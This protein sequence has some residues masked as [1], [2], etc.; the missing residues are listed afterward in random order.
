MP[1]LVVNCTFNPPVI[2]MM[3]ST[4]REETVH[5]LDQ[6]LPIVTTTS[7]SPK[8]ELPK[9]SY[10]QNPPHWHNDLG[11][12]FCDQLGRSMIFL[13]MIECL[14]GEDWKLKG[15]NTVTHP[16]NGKDTTKFFFFREG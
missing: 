14:E 10:V 6:R 7:V 11:Q 3:G 12:H 13:T 16:D 4:L 15:T 8:K 1:H 2:K 5:K 9:F